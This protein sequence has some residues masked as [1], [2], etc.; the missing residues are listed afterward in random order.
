MTICVD[1]N[2][3]DTGLLSSSALLGKTTT[4]DYSVIYLHPTGS[5]FKHLFIGETKLKNRIQKTIVHEIGHAMGL[6]HSDVPN[7]NPI[8][9]STYSVMRQGFPDDVKSGTV[10]QEHEYYDIYSAYPFGD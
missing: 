2:G 6:G 10:P 1:I 5:P 8:S 7:Y 9:N 3:N 4:I